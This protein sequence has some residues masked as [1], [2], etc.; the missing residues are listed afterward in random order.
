LQTTP[1]IILGDEPTGNLDTST[2]TTIMQLLTELN[3]DQGKH[4]Y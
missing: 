3:K 2:G 1:K 4:L